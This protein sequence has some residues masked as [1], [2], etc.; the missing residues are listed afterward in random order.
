[1]PK[2][3][4][5]YYNK[6][7]ISPV[8]YI[9]NSVQEH[10]ERRASLYRSLG[11]PSLAFRGA[12]VLEV[13]V[14]SGQNSLYVASRMPELLTLVEPNPTGI[15]EIRKLYANTSVPHTEPVLV[16]MTLQDYVPEHQFDIVLCENWLGRV[17]H[18]KALLRKLAGFVAPD[19]I[20]VVTTLT[21][22]GFLPNLI[23]RALSVK[24]CDP[25]LPFAERTERLVEMFAPHL[26]YMSAMT[27]SATDWVQDNMMNPAYYDI[28]LT[29]PDV[30]QEVGDELNALG[31]N[32]SFSTDWRWFKA[33]CGEAREFNRHMIDEYE[34][35]LHN[36][37]D[38]QLEFS[39]TDVALNCTIERACIEFLEAT[40]SYE[41][42]VLTDQHPAEA[43]DKV[44]G[45]LEAII[46]QIHGF[47][48]QVRLGLA[49]GLELLLAEH[50]D[51]REVAKA[52]PFSRLFGRET[53]YLS[54]IADKFED[55]F[56]TRE[57]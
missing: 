15:G 18:E 55:Q 28:C 52:S 47:P 3:H 43:L 7:G 56:Y 29:I 36:F 20:M 6:H 16:E 25:R 34:S 54:L 22:T 14:G 40:C 51:F 27:R 5:D 2:S 45:I 35:Q 50:G 4:L 44:S 9:A 57:Q 26:G 42:A 13:A 21:P 39:Q 11:L 19:G 38:Y 32:P 24:Y 33:V 48:D 37:F 41:H 10:F 31:T 30:L 23:R 1:M 49:A 53:V 17:P 8:H 46:A 12:R